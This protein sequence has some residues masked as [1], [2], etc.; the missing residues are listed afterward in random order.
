MR[1]TIV[2]V[3]IVRIIVYWGLYW[4]HPPF[5]GETTIFI[6]VRRIDW[7]PEVIPFLHCCGV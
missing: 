4:G 7:A 1:G 2:G 5:F 3:P 6:S